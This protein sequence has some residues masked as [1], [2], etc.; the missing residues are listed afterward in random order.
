MTSNA[1]RWPTCARRRHRSSSRAAAA[2]CSIPRTASSCAPPASSCGCG[3]PCHVLAARVG[4]GRRARCCRR[5]DRRADAPRAA[6]RTGLRSDGALRR[7]HRGRRHR[8]RRGCGARRLRRGPG[9]S[10]RLRRRPRCTRLRH[11]R[12][13][14]TRLPSSTSSRDRRRVADRHTSEDPGRVPLTVERALDRR[15]RRAREVRDR[16]RR[17]R[18]DARH[19]RGPV[20]RVRA[21]GPAPQRRGRRGRRRR[22]RRHRRVHRGRVLPRRRRR[23]GA[24]DPARDGRRRDRR[25]DRREPA[26]RARTSSARSTSR[27]RCSPIPRCSRRCPI[28]S[29]AAASA[30]SRSTR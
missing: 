8:R 16:R 24:D 21:M 15:G 19:R 20:P 14:P 7:R 25:Q 23:A 11:R 17:G 10:V 4:D 28:A 26:R 2:P 3:R 6:A 1:R 29:T 30:R 22:R 9:M 12:R 27:W 5:P 18:E 13:G